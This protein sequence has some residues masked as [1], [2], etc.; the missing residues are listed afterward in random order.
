MSQ[1]R[2]ESSGERKAPAAQATNSA[3]DIGAALARAQSALNKVR[4]VHGANEQ[5]LELSGKTVGMVRK[6]LRDV[7]NIPGDANAYIDSN[8]V[9]DDVVVEPG[10]TLEFSKE[11]GVKGDETL[12]KK[13]LAG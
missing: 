1:E 8:N 9:G 11:A 3:P 4:V 13:S 7:F 10:Q 6:S 2:M 5:Y 12:C